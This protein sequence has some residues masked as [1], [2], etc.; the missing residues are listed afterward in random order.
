MPISSITGIVLINNKK[1]AER[2]VTALEK[3]I[4]YQS[5]GTEFSGRIYEIKGTK[6]KEFFK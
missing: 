5:R 3:A 4:E 1:S 2:F 6:V